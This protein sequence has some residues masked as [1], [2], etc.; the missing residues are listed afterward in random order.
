MAIVT[1]TTDWGSKDFYVAALK[2]EILGVLPDA[3][4]IDIS[5][6]VDPYDLYQTKWVLGNS[7]YHFPEGSVHIIGVKGQSGIQ[8]PLKEEERAYAIAAK[9]R[10]HYFIGCNDGM[11]S[12]LFGNKPDDVYY[13]L[14][15]KGEKVMPDYEVL[16]S[17]AV[18][19]LSGGKINKVGKPV[20]DFVIKR[21]AEPYNDNNSI[22]GS[23]I[24]VNRFG[25]LV[26]NVT[27]SIFD[28]IVKDGQFEILLRKREHTIKEVSESYDNVVAG[29][30]VALF[31][32]AGHLEIAIRQGI[33][34]KML[35]A[36]VGDTIRIELK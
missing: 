4:I 18:F 26:T 7:W 5:H 23:I 32:S 22:S 17:A 14:T 35:G 3:R 24:F 13:I 20:D 31:N 9:F 10:D 25:N 19:L 33:A 15:S 28:D 30:I 6:D 1:L 36:N 2:G 16:S 21:L 11:M 29:E 8:Q 12:I 27:R 34:N